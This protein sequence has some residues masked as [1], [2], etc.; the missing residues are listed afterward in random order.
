[1]GGILLLYGGFKFVAVKMEQD[2]KLIDETIREYGLD[3]II[4]GKDFLKAKKE[5]RKRLNQ[6]EIK[7]SRSLGLTRDMGYSLDALFEAVKHEVDK[8]TVIKTALKYSSLDLR[9]E[10]AAMIS[11]RNDKRIDFF[12][13][14]A[15]GSD[16]GLIGKAIDELG[17]K[18]LCWSICSS[19]EPVVEGKYLGAP[20]NGF[21][22]ESKDV[23]GM[24]TFARES[25][26]FTRVDKSYA[27]QIAKLIG[28]VKGRDNSYGW[29]IN[30]LLEAMGKKDEC[31]GK[32]SKGVMY[33]CIVMGERYGLD[34]AAKDR[35]ALASLL[36]D[37]GKLCVDNKILKKPAKLTK[38]EYRIMKKHSSWGAE[39]IERSEYLKFLAKVIN[40]HHE[41][42][43][44][45]GYPTGT[46]DIP[47]ESRII[48]VAD[49]YNAMTSDRPYR[50]GGLSHEIAD[51]EI[52]DCAGTQFTHEA[53]EVYNECVK[54]GIWQVR[55]AV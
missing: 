38:E 25:N 5:I 54:K 53:V 31:T 41:R 2:I 29:V 27:N 15:K 40:C 7:K 45:K 11:L 35:L 13:D 1:M 30:K 26:S 6:L 19:N 32:H 12:V 42:P 51:K 24:L 36:H 43:D 39:I 47:I 33:N 55:D 17:R 48:A 21:G 28:L 4:H 23:L 44:G 49:T 20:I 8:E 34:D 3:A 52:N 46:K 10:G 9:A 16:E 18:N 22:D 50:R 37:V 14:F